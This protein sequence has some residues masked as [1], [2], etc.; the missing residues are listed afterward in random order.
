ME[1]SRLCIDPKHCEYRETE[2]MA[3]HLLTRTDTTNAKIIGSQTPSPRTFTAAQALN[4]QNCRLF[5]KDMQFFE[6]T[7]PLF[8]I[9]NEP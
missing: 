8:P 1:N 3:C 5:L 2:K 7:V 4:K 6:Y 9:S